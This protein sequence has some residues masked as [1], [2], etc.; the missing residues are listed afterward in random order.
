MLAVLCMKPL[1]AVLCMGPSQ[2]AALCMGMWLLVSTWQ[3]SAWGCRSL[4]AVL[5]V[6]LSVVSLLVST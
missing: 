6:E 5:C 3:C 2:L 1:L 4:P